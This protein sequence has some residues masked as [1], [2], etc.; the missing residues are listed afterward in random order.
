MK[1]T[2]IAL[3]AASLGLFLVANPPLA[4]DRSDEQLIEEAT[5]AL[6]EHLRAEASVVTTDTEGNERVL[7][8]GSN[9]FKCFP[10]GYDQGFGVGCLEESL[11][12]FLVEIPELARDRDSAAERLTVVEAGIKEG[13]ITPPPP[14]ARGYVLSGLDRERARLTLAI[15]LPGATAESTGLST[16]RSDGTWLMC[17]GTPDAHI[18][19]GDIP[20]GRDENE[21]KVCSR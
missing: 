12:G 8:K 6:P 4:A 16:E 21:W 14:G 17:P 9:G 7:R 5:A 10:N 20:Y 2:S 15:F 3:F 13:S 18:M 1:L 11:L 19:V